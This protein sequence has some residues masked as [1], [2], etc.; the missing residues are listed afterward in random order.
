MLLGYARAVLLNQKGPNPIAYRCF[1]I[2][3]VFRGNVFDSGDA[4]LAGDCWDVYMES[5]KK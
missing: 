5:I 4:G 2:I 1:T 3:Q